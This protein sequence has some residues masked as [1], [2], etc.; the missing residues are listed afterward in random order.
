MNFIRKET[1]AILG[2]T[3]INNIPEARKY[4]FKMSLLTK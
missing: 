1:L 3:N 4:E 2:Q